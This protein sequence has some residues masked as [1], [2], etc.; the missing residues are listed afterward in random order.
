MKCNRCGKEIND[1]EMFC[2]ECKKYLKKFSS[3][4]E[5]EELEDLIEE[6]RNLTDLENTKELVNLD[7]LV[8]EELINQEL[9]KDLEEKTQ[10]FKMEEDQKEEKQDE[11]E[12]I[13]KDEEGYKKNKKKII[14][15]ISI[16][17]VV[18]IILLSLLIIL[19]TNNKKEDTNEVEIDYKKVINTYG[20]KITEIVKE[21]KNEYEDIPT[22]QFVISKLNYDRYEVEC[23]THNIYNDGS[24]YLSSCKVNNKKTK[25]TYGKEQEEIKE[26]KKI[27]IYKEDRNGIVSYSNSSNYPLVGTITC[28]TEECIFIEAFDKYVLIEEE[29]FNYLYDYTNDSISFGPF[30]TSSTIDYL[31]RD[32]YLYGIYYQE[33]GKNNI[34]NPSTGKILKDIKGELLYSN[35]NVD[36]TLMYKYNYVILKNKGTNEF[37]NLKTGNVSYSIK[38]TLRNVNED[39]N[40]KIVYITSYTSDYN[41]FKIYNSNGKSLFDGLEYSNFIIGTNNLLVSTNTNFKVYDK[42]L[43]KKTNSKTYDQILGLYEDFVVVAKENDLLILSTDETVLATYEDEYTTSYTFDNMSSGWTD[44]NKTTICLMFENNKTKY[45]Y[46][47]NTKE[48]NIVRI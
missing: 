19:L 38:G 1:I 24:V 3:R 25:Y 43:N 29:G 27:N 31:I 10:I 2:D 6:N 30:K 13:F 45:Y 33:D 22:W 26:G 15:I 37:V 39:Q 34:Y 16:V 12:D 8:E 9:K 42:D 44:N 23:D 11:M 21:Y 40:K 4:R 5:V 48:I 41:K 14:I 7:E 32:N 47:V 46:N 35:M 17:S 18:V 20:D 36:T 28:K